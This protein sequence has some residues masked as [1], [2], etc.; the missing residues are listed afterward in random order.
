MM[1]KKKNLLRIHESYNN[2]NCDHITCYRNSYR[3]DKTKLEY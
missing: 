2:A 1:N 3:T